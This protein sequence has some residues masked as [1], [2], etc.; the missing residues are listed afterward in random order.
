MAITK[1]RAAV[2]RLLE[3]KFGYGLKRGLFR[4]SKP[5][6]NLDAAINE[7]ERKLS[8]AVE[9]KSEGLTGFTDPK[10][11]YRPPEEQKKPSVNW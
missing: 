10:V 11:H 8:L 2:A 6:V 4:P 5:P 3:Q 1:S 9:E 7:S